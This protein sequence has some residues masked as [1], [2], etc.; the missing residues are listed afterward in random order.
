MLYGVGALWSQ[1]TFDID[2]C[3]YGIPPGTAVIVPA[4]YHGIW[5]DS[6]GTKWNRN[7]Q[8]IVQKEKEE[9]CK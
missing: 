6:N 1:F 8:E 5:Y 3:A 2:L 9:N 4:C 7:R